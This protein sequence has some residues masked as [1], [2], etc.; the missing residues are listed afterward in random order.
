[1]ILRNGDRTFAGRVVVLY[2][3]VDHVRVSRL[4]VFFVGEDGVDASCLRSGS[5]QLSPFQVRAP[6]HRTRPGNQIDWHFKL[7]E[8]LRQNKK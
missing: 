6:V 4:S 8:D 2:L 7:K 1:M 3:P 5:F